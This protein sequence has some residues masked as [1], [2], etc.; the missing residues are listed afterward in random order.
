MAINYT[1]PVKT[2]PTSADDIL[3]IDNADASKS[4]KRI[5][6]STLPINSSITLTTVGTSGVSTLTGTTLNVPDYGSGAVTNITAQ[7][8]LASTGGTTPII[9][10]GG[11]SSI[12]SRGQ[13]IAVASGGTAL[14]YIDPGVVE[15][16]RASETILQGDP[17]YI[18]GKVGGITTVGRAQSGNIDK[19]PC[20]GIARA[21]ITI[22]TEGDM[23]VIGVLGG[24]PMN[25]LLPGA[26]ENDVVYVAPTGGV[27]LIKPTGTNLIQNIGI[28]SKP[29][30]T[31]SIQVTAIGR[32]NDLPNVPQGNIWLGD[33]NSVPVALP[34]GGA[35]TVLTSNGT[36][37]SWSTGVANYLPLT[38]GTMT[39]SISGVPSIEIGTQTLTIDGSGD[40]T[41]NPSLG[42]FAYID[43]LTGINNF[44]VSLMPAGVTAKVALINLT[45]TSSVSGWL[46]NGNPVKWPGVT[47]PT[48]S[49]S[50]VDIVTFE[51]IGTSVYASIIQGY[52]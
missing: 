20:V 36:T 2:T 10:L 35:G 3:I 4:T 11:L 32:S 30:G 13:L 8:P 22:N 14:N 31:G 40:T 37:A 39:G 27:T 7:S 17:L 28:V 41:F 46:V 26:S 19:M 25:T 21:E 9:S 16:V 29:I 23:Y 48:I 49:N 33:S 50:G 45:G 38:G 42:A 43:P 5:S 15:I 34:I 52:A 6:I 12:G 44:N 24:L 51:F 47:P 18:T 1:Y